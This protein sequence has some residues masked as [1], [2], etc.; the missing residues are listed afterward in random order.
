MNLIKGKL[1]DVVAF[2]DELT[3]D[4]SAVPEMLATREA[5]RRNLH[6]AGGWHPKGARR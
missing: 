1:T 2:L 4:G 5:W 6:R 3:Y